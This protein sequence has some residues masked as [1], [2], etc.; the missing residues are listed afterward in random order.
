[1]PSCSGR[2]NSEID[3]KVD[4][5]ATGKK[6]K[7]PSIKF[8]EARPEI[9]SVLYPAKEIK[10]GWLQGEKAFGTLDYNLTENLCQ[11]RMRLGTPSAV[12]EQ[13]K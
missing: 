2:R 12:C 6:K 1:M 9:G 7:Y 10:R 11:P 3:P 5:V 13:R 8:T 4:K